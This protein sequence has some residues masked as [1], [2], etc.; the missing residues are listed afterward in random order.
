MQTNVLKDLPV[1]F[2]EFH[3]TAA[4]N[5]QLNRFY[6]QG[7]FTKEELLAIA[8]QIDGFESWISLFQ[9]LGEEAEKKKDPL[10]AA[11]C[12]R[13]AQFYTLSDEK[14]DRSKLFYELAVKAGLCHLRRHSYALRVF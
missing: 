5:F 6:S 14:D 12:Y 4:F 11:T 7:V 2:Y 10:R 3:E 13:A 9:R 8:K 1:G